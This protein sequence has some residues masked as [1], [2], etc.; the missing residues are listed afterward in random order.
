MK[1]T[2]ICISC[3]AKFEYERPNK[4]GGRKRKTCN[5]CKMKQAQEVARRADRSYRERH[6]GVVGCGSGNNQCGEKNHQWKGGRGKPFYRR[7]LFEK[8]GKDTVC[9]NCGEKPKELSQLLVHHIDRNRENNSPENLVP[10]CKRCHQMEHDC[11]E[12]LR[13]LTQEQLQKAES[14]RVRDSK[15]RYTSTPK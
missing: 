4:N 8:Y 2:V 3:G 6:G 1:L 5:V 12:Q 10:M 15:G 13:N 11:H 9:S 14:K 7:V